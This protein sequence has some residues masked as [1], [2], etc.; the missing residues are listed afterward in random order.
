MIT[1]TLQEHAESTAEEITNHFGF[2]CKV[3]KILHGYHIEV[4]SFIGRYSYN[5]IMSEFGYMV[6]FYRFCYCYALKLS[7]Y[8]LDNKIKEQKHKK[9]VL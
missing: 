7:R 8:G 2:I 5:C 4:D 3:I 9:K 6:E 1:S